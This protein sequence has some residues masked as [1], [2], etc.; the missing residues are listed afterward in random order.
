MNILKTK[1]DSQCK[2]EKHTLP[3]TT[4]PNNSLWAVNS[5]AIALGKS[6]SRVITNGVHHFLQRTPEVCELLSMLWGEGRAIRYIHSPVVTRKGHAYVLKL[7]MNNKLGINLWMFGF[8]DPRTTLPLKLK[9]DHNW[10]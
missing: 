3:G 1:H 4:R 5:N 10:N 9:L 6:F 7:P 8:T 2:T